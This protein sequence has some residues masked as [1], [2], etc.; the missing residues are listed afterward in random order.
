MSKGVKKPEG[1]MGIVR[2]IKAYSSSSSSSAKK[3]SHI[4]SG[5]K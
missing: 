4:P 2:H 5:H 1:T 3:S